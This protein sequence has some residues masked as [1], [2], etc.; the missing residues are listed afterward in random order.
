VALG[1]AQPADARRA[2]LSFDTKVCLSVL[3][4]LMVVTALEAG[5]IMRRL[6]R[7]AAVAPLAGGLCAGAIT[8]AILAIMSRRSGCGWHWAGLTPAHG[9]LGAACLLSTM[10]LVAMARGWWPGLVSPL[11]LASGFGLFAMGH[12]TRLILTR[13]PVEP[14]ATGMIPQRQGVA[15]GVV[16]L[17]LACVGFALTP[18][19]LAWRMSCVGDGMEF[20]D[21]ID[22]GQVQ[23]L[24]ELLNQH[25][26]ALKA[27]DLMGLGLLDEAALHGQP[28]AAKLLLQRG[29]DPNAAGTFGT[30]PIHCAA[31]AGAKDVLVLLLAAGADPNVEDAHGGTPLYYAAEG[32]HDECVR[33]LLAHGARH[34][35]FSAAA[36]GDLEALFHF[37]HVADLDGREVRGRTPLD[38]AA[39]AGHA[40][41]VDALLDAG[42][43]AEAKD[44]AGRTP[45]LLAAINGRRD[46]A[47]ALL[48]KGADPDAADEEATTPLHA[49][50]RAGDV[51]MAGL[52]MDSGADPNP[53]DGQGLTPMMIA[54]LAKDEQMIKLL[55]LHGVPKM[56][57]IRVGP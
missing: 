9:L 7:A 5:G 24:E 28:E 6:V 53:R 54:V 50:A 44:G 35:I 25:P 37:I 4:A 33:L 40:P 22:N 41:I 16:L 46:A 3:G 29:A 39:A 10:W 48:K 38:V 30:R 55:Q 1:M 32:N 45:L 26:G 47:A 51:G 57:V 56:K 18:A 2:G 14:E 11:F 43:D 20:S 49:A 36:T 12:G 42:A 21:A 27:F 19:S 52:L 8:V 17:F 23:R 15:L 34:D 13:E 31:M